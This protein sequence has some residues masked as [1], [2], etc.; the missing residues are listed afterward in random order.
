MGGLGPQGGGQGVGR[1]EHRSRTQGQ[2]LAVSLLTH[3]TR[4]PYLHPFSL[5]CFLGRRALTRLD[6][7]VMGRSRVREGPQER[8]ERSPTLSLPVF[9]SP[10]DNLTGTGQD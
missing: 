1:D 5:S 7:L 2:D 9:A 10:S 6:V 4:E 3:T 8:P